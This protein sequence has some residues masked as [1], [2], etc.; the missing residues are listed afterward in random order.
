MRK[1]KGDKGEGMQSKEMNMKRAT[2]HTHTHT[3]GSSL[4]IKKKLKKKKELIL[5]ALLFQMFS[6]MCGQLWVLLLFGDHW[7]E[8]LFS[9][10]VLV[11]LLMHWIL[12]QAV[13]PVNVFILRKQMRSQGGEYS[14]GHFSH[15]IELEQMFSPPREQIQ[16]TESVKCQRKQEFSWLHYWPHVPPYGLGHQTDWKLP[17][18]QSKLSSPADA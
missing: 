11:A 10:F 15:Q 14:S 13:K 16:V 6:G 9:P 12:L 5:A 1:R 17:Q 3:L 2:T 8:A 18:L 4:L 7:V